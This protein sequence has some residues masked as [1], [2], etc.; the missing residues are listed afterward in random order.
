MSRWIRHR[1]GARDHEMRLDR[2]FRQQ[3][4]W[5]PHSFLHKQLR[6][7]K[8]RLQL[9]SCQNPVDDDTKLS[10]AQAHSILREGATVA[11]DAHL[12]R[13]S[14]REDSDSSVESLS[15][16]TTIVSDQQ[17]RRLLAR[18]VYQDPNFFILD[19]PHGLAVQDGSGLE[20]SLAAYFDS[21][22]ATFG[23]E[24]PRLVH[25]L[26]K[27]TS[28]LLVL[29]RHRL[30][31][32]RFSTLLQDGQVQKTYDALV[33]LPPQATQSELKTSR[34]SGII[35]SPINGLDACTR[36]F[37]N[38]EEQP[39]HENELWL[40]MQPVSG[41][42]HQLRIHCAQVLHAPIVGD[43]KYGYRSRADRLFLH[44]R[45]IEFPNPFNAGQSIAL[46]RS[47]NKRYPI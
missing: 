1:I 46:E 45:R 25:R 11:I 34:S 40:R 22:A 38:Q 29:A 15:S 30:A 24:P 7:R 10:S 32:A 4:P 19:K 37:K 35:R 44:A 21:F 36:W 42:K 43:L 3:F 13:T 47:M 9:P 2:W 23:G 6:K 41:R 16:A 28:G 31:A 14:L 8:I 17:Q 39:P 20:H 18:V 5:V 26:D 27:E 33:A 12:L